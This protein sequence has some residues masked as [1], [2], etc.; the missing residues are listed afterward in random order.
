ML[1]RSLAGQADLD[2]QLAQKIVLS[3]EI[4]A[5]SRDIA[6][7]KA[8]PHPMA[9]KGSPPGSL[10]E[11]WGVMSDDQEG[12]EAVMARG[13]EVMTRETEANFNSL[14][15]GEP[16][17]RRPKEAEA[18]SLAGLYDQQGQDLSKGADQRRFS[19]NPRIQ[20]QSAFC[21]LGEVGEERG[22]RTSWR[23]E[24][25]W[26][27]NQPTSPDSHRYRFGQPPRHREEFLPRRLRE[28]QSWVLSNPHGDLLSMRNKMSVADSRMEFAARFSA[29]GRG[30]PPYDPGYGRHG[31]HPQ[32][33]QRRSLESRSAQQR[34]RLADSRPQQLRPPVL[35]HVPA[36]QPLQPG[37]TESAAAVYALPQ[38]NEEPAAAGR[39]AQQ[40]GDRMSPAEP[41]LYL[42]H[43]DELDLL[44]FGRGG[45]GGRNLAGSSNNN[46]IPPQNI[47]NSAT[48]ANLDTQQQQQ[49]Q[50][51]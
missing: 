28:E 22:P 15:M 44:L 5:P 1:N 50:Y 38:Q 12:S 14:A 31:L 9:R 42:S 40:G 49:Q 46:D 35:F 48:A 4:M 24:L 11:Q 26:P 23:P 43:G 51:K 29:A 16:S 2:S 27:D 45:G 18:W 41:P 39:C 19:E 10:M 34:G 13:T 20:S 30:S 7:L 17:R 32:E 47:F 6:S 3:E 21:P 25:S 37:E 8:K 33:Q 36:R